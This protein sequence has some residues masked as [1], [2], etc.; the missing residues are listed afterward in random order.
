L[1]REHGSGG[2]E[3]VGESREKDLGDGSG[4]ARIMAVCGSPGPARKPPLPP[5]RVGCP[6]C[7]TASGRT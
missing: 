2:M 3:E 5:N 6:V 1:G 4:A 7:G